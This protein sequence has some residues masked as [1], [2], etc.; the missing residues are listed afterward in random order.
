MVVNYAGNISVIGPL[1]PKDYTPLATKHND[2]IE[3]N[4]DYDTFISK[5][6]YH[7]KL[8]CLECKTEYTLG[9]NYKQISI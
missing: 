5:S 7:S 8:V 3:V 9:N 6:V 2:E 1:C 4:V